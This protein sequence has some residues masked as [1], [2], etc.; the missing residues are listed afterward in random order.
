MS[1]IDD[2]EDGP[3]QRTEKYRDL[4]SKLEMKPTELA[5]RLHAL[6]D[7]RSSATIMRSIQR[8]SS[9]ETAVS[10]D[11]LVLMRVLVLQQQMRERA[12]AEVQWKSHPNR[13]W[14]TTLDGFRVTL[15]PQ[16]NDRWLIN[17]EDEKTGFSPQWQPWVTGL[18]AAKRK[19]LV[20]VAD[21]LLDMFENLA[22]T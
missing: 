21:G 2:E 14:K 4:V 16:S 17:L 18:D 5:K 7:F 8:M 19:V 22:E 11:S 13:V 10:A 6:G 9:G 20:C 1:D 3:E 15:L 12:H